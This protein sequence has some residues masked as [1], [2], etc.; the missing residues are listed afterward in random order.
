MEKAQ[1]A[2]EVK[3]KVKNIRKES[4]C[5]LHARIVD[6]IIRNAKQKRVSKEPV[7]EIG[8]VRGGN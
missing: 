7:I 4:V 2:T 5:H 3:A 8:R 6:E 1:L